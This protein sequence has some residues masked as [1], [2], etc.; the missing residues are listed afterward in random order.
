ML[1]QGDVF[2]IKD[3]ASPINS[4]ALRRITNLFKNPEIVEV[5]GNYLEKNLIHQASDGTLVINDVEKLPDFTIEND[6]T[7][8]VFYWEHCGMLHVPE[9]LARWEE[10]K[11]WY[12]ENDIKP[13]ED[14]GGSNGTLIISQD[15]LQSLSDGSLRGSISVQ[16]IDELIKKAF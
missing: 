15:N 13:L 12:I 3:L 1:F 7:G 11:Q 9:Y 6:D 2:D 4:D 14:G 8:E 5:K 16:E 10:K